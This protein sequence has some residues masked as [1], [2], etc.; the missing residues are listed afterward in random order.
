MGENVDFFAIEGVADPE[1]VR[2]LAAS[3]TS[4]A[5]AGALARIL[6]KQ[7]GH[8]L[9]FHFAFGKGEYAGLRKRTIRRLRQIRRLATELLAEDADRDPAYRFS[10]CLDDLLSEHAV[11]AERLKLTREI[12]NA[13]AMLSSLPLVDNLIE[14]R[15][16]PSVDGTYKAVA[17]AVAIYW[18]SFESTPFAGGATRETKHGVILKR[19]SPA[20]L[21][22][23][24]FDALDMTVA[25]ATIETLLG[26][27]ADGPKV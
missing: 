10:A 7:C 6:D 4:P 11:T 16:P 25:P 1:L 27:I 24:V 20:G 17:S 22:K 15:K 5:D 12:A 13:L 9:K 8:A 14:F 21:L 18:T 3:E 23:C 26:Q 19:D 2:R